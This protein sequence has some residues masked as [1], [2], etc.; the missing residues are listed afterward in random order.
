MDILNRGLEKF[1]AYVK[2]NRPD[3]VEVTTHKHEGGDAQYV[4]EYFGDF[5]AQ[6]EGK[7]PFVASKKYGGTTSDPEKMDAALDADIK[8][9]QEMSFTV[10]KTKGFQDETD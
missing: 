3:T 5:I 8:R 1:I 7:K 6:Y 2:K 9:L 10:F 4:C